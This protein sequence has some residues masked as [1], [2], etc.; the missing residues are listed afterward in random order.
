[1]AN[2]KE[3]R[4]AEKALNVSEAGYYDPK[5]D[6]LDDDGLPKRTGIACSL[7]R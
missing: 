2:E 5:D 3:Y 1:M 6:S 4:G 7:W